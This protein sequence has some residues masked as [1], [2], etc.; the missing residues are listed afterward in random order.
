MKI[1]V[2]KWGLPLIVGIFLSQAGGWTSVSAYST[3][4]ISITSAGVSTSWNVPV[5][6]S[7]DTAEFFNNTNLN[8]SIAN[9]VYPFPSLNW[10]SIYGSNGNGIYYQYFGAVGLVAVCTITRACDETNASYRV[11][12]TRTAGVWSSDFVVT[13]GARIID[14]VPQ[15]DDQV[16]STTIGFQVTIDNDTAE[17][18]EIL[19]QNMDDGAGSFAGGLSNFY[20]PTAGAGVYT[21]F[22][23]T[24]V[25]VG[26]QYGSARLIGGDTTA[27]NQLPF[28]VGFTAVSSN[29]DNI[30]FPNI[31]GAISSTTPSCVDAN[32]FQNAL[33]AV[34]I[35]S[36][37]SINNFTQL[38]STTKT[39][40]PFAYF[41]Q[42]KTLLNGISSTTAS[43]TL[44][45][46]T[47]TLGTSTS[48]FKPTSVVMFSPQTLRTFVPDSVSATIR[49]VTT[50]GLWIEFLWYLWH[51]SRRLIQH[52][53]SASK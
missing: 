39:K 17:N 13:T 19:L 16:A 27:V 44:P 9:I 38:A 4:P 33:C 3:A 53:H 30:N 22:A 26:Y 14:V 43:T 15:Y 37:Q 23:T 45:V 34:F 28:P 41:F 10:E 47:W 49:V 2:L 29:Y 35:P 52:A 32:F 48:P 24:T 8:T 20:I 18:V 36:P 42:I 51:R 5:T 46:M 6:P 12:F 7:Y 25:R 50:A 40:L 21:L 11:V 31:G 1:K